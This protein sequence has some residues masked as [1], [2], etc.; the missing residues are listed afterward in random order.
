MII[1][2]EKQAKIGEIHTTKE[3]VSKRTG[4]SLYKLRQ[5]LDKKGYYEDD[6]W[7]IIPNSTLIK[8]KQRN[9]NP[10]KPTSI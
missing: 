6:S 7:I 10:F 9:K 4:L 5:Y 2:I 1:I 3:G 8:G